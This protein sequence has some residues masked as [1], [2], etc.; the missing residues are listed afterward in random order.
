MIINKNRNGIRK[1]GM[2]IF[3]LFIQIIWHVWLWL[4]VLFHIYSRRYWLIY[5]LLCFVEWLL[6]ISLLKM[7]NQDREIELKLQ[8]FFG[9]VKFLYYQYS[10]VY[11]KYYTN[12]CWI[13]WGSKGSLIIC[14][15]FNFTYQFIFT[16][17]N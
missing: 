11:H 16:L 13:N 5:I 15:A 12:H 3:L 9:S 4:Y 1:F 10:N 6:L 7:Q 17:I 8:E 14:L 2:C